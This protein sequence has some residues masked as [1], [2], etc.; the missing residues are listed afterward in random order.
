MARR[1]VRRPAREPLQAGQDAEERELGQRMPVHP[2]GGG[3]H[4][5][6]QALRGQVGCAQ[7]RSTAG[8]H[9]VHPPQARIGHRR[10]AQR[11]GRGVRDAEE[12]LRP[13]HDG[14]E[15]RLGRPAARE[16]RRTGVVPGEPSSRQQLRLPP[17]VDIGL[18]RAQVLHHALRDRYSHHDPFGSGCHAHSLPCHLCARKTRVNDWTGI[19]STTYSHSS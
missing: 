6:R 12:D 16:S 11:S 7:L 2:G 5:R 4:E 19:R 18:G 8:S 10:A 14:L 17:P 3:H 1:L 9:G 15:S 13:V